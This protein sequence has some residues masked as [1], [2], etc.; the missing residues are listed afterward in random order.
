M[1][2]IHSWFDWLK[3]HTYKKST[4]AWLTRM[5]ENTSLPQHFKDAMTQGIIKMLCYMQ[6]RKENLQVLTQ[7]SHIDSPRES[8]MMD[9]C[10]FSSL[11]LIESFYLV[12]A[13]HILWNKAKSFYSINQKDGIFINISKIT[14]NYTSLRI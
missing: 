3:T 14:D 10:S 2:G 1:I 8:G 11:F 9:Q 7:R 6:F 13:I 4:L 5:L 12:T